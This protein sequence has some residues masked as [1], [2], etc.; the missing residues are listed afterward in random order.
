MKSF[1]DLGKRFPP[2]AGVYAVR[3]A[4]TVISNIINLIKYKYKKGEYFFK[5][6][7]IQ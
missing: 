7:K 6:T 1:Y 3:M 5:K 4:P 2:K